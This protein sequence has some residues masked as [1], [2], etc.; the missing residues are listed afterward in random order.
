MVAKILKQTIIQ[1]QALAFGAPGEV[2]Q[3]V[4]PANPLPVGGKQE[5]FI[6]AANNAASGAVTVYGGDYILAQTAA[7]YGTVKLQ[8]LGPNGTTWLDLVSLP[9]SDENGA[10]TGIALPNGAQLRII[11]AGTTGAYATLKRVP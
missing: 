5:S 4:T 7:A 11:L 2:A 6:L 8:I 1:I 3:P 9:A 10:G